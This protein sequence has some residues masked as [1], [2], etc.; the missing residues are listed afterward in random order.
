MLLS[1]SPTHRGVNPHYDLKPAS[2]LDADTSRTVGV[3]WRL[4][5]IVKLAG[6]Y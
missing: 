4:E 6:E 2:I 1:D 3:T 5:D